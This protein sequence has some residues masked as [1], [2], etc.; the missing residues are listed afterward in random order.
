M[1]AVQDTFTSLATSELRNILQAHSPRCGAARKSRPELVDLLTTCFLQ[2]EERRLANA[3]RRSGPTPDIRSYLIQVHRDMFNTYGPAFTMYLLSPMRAAHSILGKYKTAVVASVLAS[4]GEDDATLR[5]DNDVANHCTDTEIGPDW[6]QIISQAEKD[7][8]LQA[9]VDHTA[10]AESHTC[11]VC[12]RRTFTQDLL[13]T[14]KHLF[15]QRYPVSALRLEILR[16]SDPHLLSQPSDMFE[17]GDPALHGLALDRSGVHL[18]GNHTSLDICNECYK[19]LSK[20]NQSLPALSLANGNFRGRLPE[21]L[22]DCTWLEERL[23]A[24]YLASAYIIRLFDWTAPCA[25][26]ERPRVMKGHACAFP[27]NTMSTASKLP[28]AIGEDGALLSCIVIGPRKPR[29]QDF[30]NIFRVRKQKVLDLFMFLK[31]HCK[32]YPQFELDPNA[33]NSLPVDD[34]PELIMRHV[35]YQENQQVLSLFDRETAGLEKHPGIL[36]D[37]AEDDLSGRTFLEHHGVIDVNGVTVPANERLASALSNATGQERPDLVLRHG[38]AFVQ[39]YNNPDLFPGMYPTLYPL[40]VGGFEDDRDTAL[41]FQRQAKYLLDLADPSFRRHWSFIFM[42]ANIKQR[43]AV[44]HGSQLACKRQDYERFSQTLADLDANVI[45]SVANHIARGG[46]LKTLVGVE[47]RVFELLDKCNLVSAKVPGSRSVMNRAR[48]D[49]RALIGHF[50]I[51]Q[52]FLTIN[53]GATHSPVFHIFFG[54]KTVTLDTQRPDLPGAKERSIRVADDPVAASDYFHFHVSAVFQYLLGWDIR[55]GQSTPEGGIF[56]RLA[57]YFLVK[58]HTMRGQLHCHSLLW[59]EGGMNPAAL[60]EKMRSNEEFRD[61]YL[62]FFDDIITH[63]FP[64]TSN[65]TQPAEVPIP[66]Q[67]SVGQSR[68]T[69]VNQQGAEL[70]PDLLGEELPRPSKESSALN[71]SSPATRKPRQERPPQPSQPDFQQAFEEDHRIL[72]QDVQMHRHTFTCFKGGRETC[73]FF[74]PHEVTETSSFDPTTNSINLRVQHPLINWHNPTLLVATRHNHDLKAVQSGL[75]GAAAASYITSYTT[76]S[77]E[78]PENQVSMINTVYERMAAHADPTADPHGLLTR[79]VMQFGRERQLHAQQAATYVRELGDVAQSHHTVPMLSSQIID[80]AIRLWGPTREDSEELSGTDDATDPSNHVSDAGPNNA[81]GTV[82]QD[83]NAPSVTAP[84]AADE[85]GPS[86]AYPIAE[87]ACS[88][89]AVDTSEGPDTETRPEEYLPLLG[90]DEDADAHSDNEGDEALLPL[91]TR[92]LTLQVDDYLHRGETLAQLSF[93]DFVRFVTLTK[94]PPKKPNK[95][96]HSLCVT[97]PDVKT[98][99]HRY[100]PDKPVGIPRPICRRFP[101]SNGRPF[102]GDKY[103]AAMMAHFIPFGISTPLK[104]GSETWEAAYNRTSF[105]PTAMKVMTNWSALTECEDAR[106]ADQLLRRRR[107][108]EKARKADAIA[109]Q[110]TTDA[111]LAGDFDAAMEEYM[112]GTNSQSQETVEFSAVLGGSGWFDAPA[113]EDLQPP[114]TRQA[115]SQANRRC[116]TKEQSTLEAQAKANQSTPSAATGVLAEQLRLDN[117]AESRTTTTLTGT[118]A[119]TLP[120]LPTQSMQWNDRPPEELLQALV[121]ERS[122]TASQALAFT[123]AGRKFFESMKDPDVTP[124]RLLMHGEAGTGKTVVVRLLRELMDRYGKGDQILFLAPTGKAASAIGGMTQ[125]AAFKLDIRHRGITVEELEADRHENTATRLRYLQKTFAHIRWI[126]FDEVSMTSCEMFSDI[127]QA[128]QIGTQKLDEPFGG[129]N[130]LFA[131]DFCQLPPVGAS[132]LYASG[133]SRYQN[134]NIRTKEE[135]GRLAWLYVDEVVEFVEQKRMQDPVMAATLSR[136]R[137]RACTDEDVVLLNSR[138][139]SAH[140]GHTKVTVKGRSRL[141]VLAN[142]N[143]TV[144]NLNHRKATAQAIN[145]RRRMVISHAQDKSSGALD[146]NLRKR[147]LAYNGD[148]KMKIGIGQLP[149]YVGMPVVYRGPNKCVQMGITNGAFG[150]VVDWELTTDRFGYT[151]PV[152]VIVQFDPNAT[153]R[154]SN[155][156]PGCLPIYPTVST[157]KFYPHPNRREV[158][159][160]S[161]RQLPLQPGFAMTVHSAQGVTAT[162]GIVVDLRKGGFRAYVAASRATR[163][164]DIFLIHE[165]NKQHLNKPALPQILSAELSRLDTLAQVTKRNHTRSQTQL[166]TRAIRPTA[167]GAKRASM[168]QSEQAA[169]RIRVL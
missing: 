1:P 154:L 166:G 82:H 119:Y 105:S 20:E 56:G 47:A 34:V 11:S 50:G 68:T 27:L 42:V 23:C 156:D 99:V 167:A 61:R 25:E 86:P 165:I 81:S 151:I 28:W 118:G 5:P 85:T 130:V 3:T 71:P 26:P 31:Q 41:S 36:D 147:M 22:Q 94:R 21:H 79:C 46:T 125:H 113:V 44:H 124:L 102:H 115:F 95:Q 66:S 17:Y 63:G 59:L 16:V 87:E 121:K 106:D 13:F 80:A 153:W 32:G 111:G 158:H 93:Y 90:D 12:A 52:L 108:A 149:L 150:T 18:H 159:R 120:A 2:D 168:W 107:E 29:L 133:S 64:S 54:D 132:P 92:G 33:L 136:M 15:C 169:K 76:K 74:F 65:P 145:D 100:T 83:D 123:I 69:P 48:A 155:L 89:T 161:R 116:W 9:F 58:E 78:T 55:K 135:L 139:L 143:Q 4:P 141:M 122:L 40:G 110:D 24:K 38:A 37:A 51:F 103:C 109:L 49:I 117:M 128:L 70:S 114:D 144:R 157:F 101:K 134:S 160:I 72:A 30:R 60:R 73:R 62:A 98:H 126:F 88:P 129:I 91:S 84:G 112:Q 152:G 97:H 162:G 45:K 10:I 77:D 35:V 142:T 43:R 8:C 19:D 164:E 148:S 6:P 96:H 138:V 53:P 57:G 163:Q 137:T 146:T 14:T 127:N 140:A 39:E 104:S 7:R 131:G 75:S 67:P